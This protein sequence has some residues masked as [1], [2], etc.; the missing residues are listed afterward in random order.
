VL[1]TVAGLPLHVLVIHAVV[2]G[3]PLMSLVTVLVAAR[4]RWRVRAGWA[5]ATLDAALVGV[6]LVAKESGEALL[7]RLG[8]QV[9]PEH[10]QMG[11]QMPW[12]A[13]AL[14]AAA[15]ASAVAGPRRGLGRVALALAVLTA[16]AATVWTVR[17]GHSGS[18]AV[19]GGVV[20]SG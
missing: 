13:L 7:E 9:A 4:P 2:V 16:V 20:P 10:T 8:G 3:V 14:L 18:A 12:F 11:S 15:V 17:T 5:V 6:V 19:W 1:D